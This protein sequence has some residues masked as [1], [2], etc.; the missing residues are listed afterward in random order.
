M[1]T[2]TIIILISAIF[3]GIVFF[4]QKAQISKQNELFNKYE[5]IFSIINIDEIEKYVDLQKKSLILSFGNRELELS[6]IENKSAVILKELEKTL[7]GS[8]T[9]LAESKEISENFKT[10]LNSSK[11]FHKELGDICIKEFEEMYLTIEKS[12]IKSENPELYSEIE[13]E[14]IQIAKKYSTMKNEI[15][16]K[17]FP[18]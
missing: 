18:V 15:I 11:N 6:N 16:N 12:I 5:K 9:N 14:I 3:Y 2:E 8:K 1:N 13:N 10:V 4:I 7:N 17:V